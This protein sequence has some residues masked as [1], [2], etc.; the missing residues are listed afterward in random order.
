MASKV[1][2]YPATTTC[3]SNEYFLDSPNDAEA[4]SI[5]YNEKNFIFDAFNNPECWG[6]TVDLDTGDASTLKGVVALVG[7]FPS[8]ATPNTAGHFYDE[9]KTSFVNEV[10]PSEYQSGV[11]YFNNLEEVL[12]DSFAKNGANKAAAQ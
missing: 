11:T 12:T 3:N 6:E 10:I 1:F 5:S 4:V 9:F 2:N 7:N 8:D